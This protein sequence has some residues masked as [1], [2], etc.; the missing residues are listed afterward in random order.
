[1][2]ANPYIRGEKFVLRIDLYPLKSD[3]LSVSMDSSAKQG[4]GSSP[5]PFLSLLCMKTGLEQ[6]IPPTVLPQRFCSK[7]PSEQGFQAAIAGVSGTGLDISA[8]V[9]DTFSAPS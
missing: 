2:K 5:L 7:V 1:H 8:T 4:S 6:P 3:P 9:L